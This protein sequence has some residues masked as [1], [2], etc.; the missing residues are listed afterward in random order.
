M[1]HHPQLG[2][3]CPACN[4]IVRVLRRRAL[5]RIT[6]NAHVH[7]ADKLATDARRERLRKIFT[8]LVEQE[9]NEAR[10]RLPIQL[11]ASEYAMREAAGDIEPDRVY[12]IV[13]NPALCDPEV[14]PR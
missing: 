3:F 10:K 11:T 12:L 9:E 5:R 1:K 13:T 7:W 14:D 6:D 2:L 4:P 8:D